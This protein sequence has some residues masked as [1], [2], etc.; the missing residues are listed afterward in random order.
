MPYNFHIFQLIFNTAVTYSLKWRNNNSLN[1]YKDK[2]KNKNKSLDWR[3]NKIR[4]CSISLA[5]NFNIVSKGMKRAKKE[6]K[7]RKKKKE[8]R[9]LK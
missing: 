1:I 3:L 6:K 9:K 8:E 5:S 4:L 2:E 7:R